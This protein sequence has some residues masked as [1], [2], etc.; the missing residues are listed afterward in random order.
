MARKPNDAS[1]SSTKNWH[2]GQGDEFQ[3]RD[4]PRQSNTRT[5]ID[6]G[7][8]TIHQDSMCA[9]GQNA[10][11]FDADAWKW[12]AGISNTFCK[13]QELS[14][15][16]TPL[17]IHAHGHACRTRNALNA[18]YNSNSYKSRFCST[19]WKMIT[20]PEACSHII[21]RL[22]SSRCKMSFT[23]FP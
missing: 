22:H 4:V 7:A 13:Q 11:A 12:T 1:L 8:P 5:I 23:R 2:Q 19:G 17:I 10:V 15:C 14:R 9:K 16:A 18:Q 3:S 20:S 6:H 21:K